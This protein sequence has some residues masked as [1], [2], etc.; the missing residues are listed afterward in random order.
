MVL[1]LSLLFIEGRPMKKFLISTFIITLSALSQSLIASPSLDQDREAVIKQYIG[2]LQR[3]DYKDISQLFNSNGTVIST[4]KGKVN[5]KDFFYSFLPNITSAKT[6]LHQSF[7]S[8][9]DENRYAS[10]FHFQFTLNDGEAG[11]GEYVDE[12]VF[13]D[14]SA[15]L[16]AVYMFE[17]LKFE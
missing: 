2:D 4:S 16:S 5:A 6:E 3:A 11:E 15:K 14:H 9:A 8:Q 13:M 10:R 7:V 17:N 12:F 1:L